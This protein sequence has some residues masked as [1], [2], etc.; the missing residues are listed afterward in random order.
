MAA[1]REHLIGLLA[2]YKKTKGHDITLVFDGWNSSRLK[3]EW[4]VTGGIT[5]IYSRAGEKADAVIKRIVAD[6]RKEW[7]V[8][9]SDREIAA[10]AWVRGSV[11]VPSETFLSLVDKSGEATPGEFELLDEEDSGHRRKGNSRQPS[12]RD[13]ALQRA[14]RKL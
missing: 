3:E 1:Q 13:K 11:P 9:S 12:K 2:Q 10:H 7:I 5:V 6:S 8:I 4:S 14:I